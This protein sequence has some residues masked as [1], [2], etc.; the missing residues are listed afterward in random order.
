MYIYTNTRT[1]TH[2]RTQVLDVLRDVPSVRPPLD[3][4]LQLL[5]RLQVCCVC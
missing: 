2:T 5:P 3:K 4:M 1:H